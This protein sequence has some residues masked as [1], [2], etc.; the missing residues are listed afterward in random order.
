VPEPPTESSESPAR[1]IRTQFYWDLYDFSQGRGLEVGPLFNPLVGREEADVCYVDVFSTAQ[2]LDNYAGDPNV[3]P[4]QIVDV[5]VSLMDD[6]G[7]VLGLPE[8]LAGRLP[9][10]W[11]IASHVVEH[12]PDLIGWLDQMAEVV[13]DDGVLVLAVPDKRYCFDV[14]RPL[15]SVGQLLEAHEAAHTR[16][17]LRAVY[18]HYRY[19]TTVDLHALWD[20]A[21]PPTFADRVHD[22]AAV[23]R[24]LQDARS[25]QYLDCHVWIFTP[26]SFVEQLHELRQLGL[27]SWTIDEMVPTP[28]LNHEFRVR[29][30]RIPRGTDLRR[31][32]D[33]GFEPDADMPA[34][35]RDRLRERRDRR[36]LAEKVDALET[37]LAASEAKLVPVEA[38]EEKVAALEAALER[39]RATSRDLREDRR[40]LRRRVAKLR[41]RA[42]RQDQ[43]LARLTSTAREP[44]VLRGARRLRVADHVLVPLRWLR[45]AA[46]KRA[47]T[48][49]PGR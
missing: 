6:D 22:D 41:N 7:Q 34:W 4:D 33:P 45:R 5:D 40:R 49:P 39:S 3:A 19:A 42:R 43:A 12:V 17:S 44:R 27:V 2:L 46:T 30:R 23:E 48:P 9:F 31:A 1:P 47:T 24:R 16:P 38:L 35:Q 26:E 11:A 10:D 13:V 14:H 29:L 15:T 37:A 28:P 20:G 18:D 8:A 21:D 25:G 36:A 32:R